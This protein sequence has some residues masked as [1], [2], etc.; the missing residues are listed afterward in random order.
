MTLKRASALL[1]AALASGCAAP[2]LVSTL[3][4]AAPAISYA[5]VR[6]SA[7]APGAVGAYLQRQESELNKRLRSRGWPVPARLQRL[8][9]DGLELRLDAEDSFEPGSGQ[10]KAAALSAYAQIAEVLKAFPSTVTHVLV[11]SDAADPAEAAEPA[12]GLSARRAASLQS[13][14]ISRGVPPTRLRAEGRGQREPLDLGDS[15]EVQ[16]QNRRVELVLRPV[17]Q[18]R[19]ADAWMPPAPRPPCQDCGPRRDR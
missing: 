2:P 15:A 6:T 18:G 1:A 14:L 10:L 5:G 16:R 3:P 12:A 13:Y 8:R 9:G 7:L 11:H 19:E 4:A 17:I